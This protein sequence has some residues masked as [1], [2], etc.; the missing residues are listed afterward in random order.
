MAA[1]V[2]PRLAARIASEFKDK[3][4][5]IGQGGMATAL[6]VPGM[7]DDTR[8]AVAALVNLGFAPGEALTAI[9]AAAGR[10]GDA[11]L[12]SADPRWLGPSRAAG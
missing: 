2:G 11:P 5:P 3:A 6:R 12:G 10:L 7:A 9:A 8:D 1:G 4:A